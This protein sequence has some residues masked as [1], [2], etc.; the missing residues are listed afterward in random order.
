M[1]SSDAYSTVTIVKIQY[2]H[3]ACYDIDDHLRR[4]INVNIDN[5]RSRVR[6]YV[7]YTVSSHG[8]KEFVFAVRR[9]GNIC[10]C[11]LLLTVKDA[12]IENTT[13]SQW[14]GETGM[15]EVTPSLSTTIFFAIISWHSK[16]NI[17]RKRT[18]RS[19]SED[20]RHM[21]MTGKV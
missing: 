18:C 3:G 12:G 8:L 13:L 2:A 20:I 11:L 15:E 9:S 14:N 4:F 6:T 5:T 7:W 19:L 16:H 10:V 17:I 1:G 21:C